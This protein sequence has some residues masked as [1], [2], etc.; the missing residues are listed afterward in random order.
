MKT[1]HK[2]MNFRPVALEFYSAEIG[3]LLIELRRLHYRPSDWAVDVSAGK[4][5]RKLSRTVV[6]VADDIE[7]AKSKA[8]KFAAGVV[9]EWRQ[10]IAS[11]DGID[12]V[13]EC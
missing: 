10:I 1:R 3:S 7:V 5:L 11:L 13:L 12:G 8:V 6:F 4:G 2:H 9:Y